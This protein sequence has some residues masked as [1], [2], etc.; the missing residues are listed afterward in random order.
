M[1][2]TNEQFRGPASHFCASAS[3]AIYEFLRS[4]SIVYHILRKIGVRA[5]ILYGKMSVDVM[6]VTRNHDI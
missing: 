2:V 4:K 1:P 5:S 6:R 3:I